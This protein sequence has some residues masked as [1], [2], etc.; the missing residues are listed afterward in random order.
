VNSGQAVNHQ[1][2]FADHC[3]GAD[4]E[5]ALVDGATALAWTGIDRFQ[6]PATVS[7]G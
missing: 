6:D 7:E 1:K 4:A 5:R 2:E 3:V